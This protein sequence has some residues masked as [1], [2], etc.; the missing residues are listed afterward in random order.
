MPL[1]QHHTLHQV[2]KLGELPIPDKECRVHPILIPNL[3][4]SPP[5]PLIPRLRAH[6]YIGHILHH[7]GPRSLLTLLKG[8]GWANFLFGWTRSS[9]DWAMYEVYV[10]LT[11]SGLVS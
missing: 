9:A 11:E 6:R 2:S 10:D 3:A 8:K 1:L 5:P 7:E 4:P